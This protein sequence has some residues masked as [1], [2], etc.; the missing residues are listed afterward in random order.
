MKGI[1]MI[2]KIMEY[3]NELA[4][5]FVVQTAKSACIWVAYQPKF[6]EEA[7]ALIKKNQIK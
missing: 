2:D 1:K 5:L 6:P 4:L 7:R 3:V